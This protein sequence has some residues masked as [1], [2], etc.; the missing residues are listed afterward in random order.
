MKTQYSFT[1]RK[2][3]DFELDTGAA[4]SCMGNKKFREDHRKVKVH[5]TNIKLKTLEPVGVADVEVECGGKNIK[6][7]I[8]ITEIHRH[9][10]GGTG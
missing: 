9:C 6:L 10:W 1:L 4:L 2:D 3:A 5:K 7:P 8:V